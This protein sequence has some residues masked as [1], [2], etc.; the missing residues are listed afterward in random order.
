MLAVQLEVNE[1]NAVLA[2]LAK[3]PWNEVNTILMKMGAQLNNQQSGKLNGSSQVSAGRDK[4]E[5]TPLG[6][7]AG[8]DSRH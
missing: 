4:A 3:G 8:S 2:Q 1:W 7:N 6:D 5:E